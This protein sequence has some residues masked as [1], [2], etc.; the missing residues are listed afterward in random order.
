MPAGRKSAGYLLDKP[1]R[2]ED[3]LELENA[4]LAI[5]IAD[6]TGSSSNSEQLVLIDDLL[7]NSGEPDGV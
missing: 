4:L 6:S 3:S 1:N 5:E 2:E 7:N